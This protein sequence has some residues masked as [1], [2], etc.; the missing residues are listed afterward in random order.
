MSALRGPKAV[1]AVGCVGWA[2]CGSQ[3]VL[4]RSGEIWVER[5]LSSS[6]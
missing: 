2:V 3:G 4:G 1:M 5:L 6:R